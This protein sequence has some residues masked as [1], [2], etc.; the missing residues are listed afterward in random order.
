M[1]VEESGSL[2]VETLFSVAKRVVTR[3]SPEEPED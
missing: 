3:L 1:V 2:V